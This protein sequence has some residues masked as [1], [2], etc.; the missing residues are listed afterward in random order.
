MAERLPHKAARS[1]VTRGCQTSGGNLSAEEESPSACFV[2]TVPSCA[3]V[4]IP[5]QREGTNVCANT[6]LNVEESYLNPL[7]AQ[8][9]GENWELKSFEISSSCCAMYSSQLVDNW[10]SWWASGQLQDRVVL[11][12]CQTSQ[13]KLLWGTM[14]RFSPCQ[15][16]TWISAV[17][18]PRHLKRILASTSK[19]WLP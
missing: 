10:S 12:C 15:S 4:G 7:A 11:P 19:P 16:G 8:L 2:D 9:C 3:L 5:W 14:K 18:T 6:K 13:R 1:S 17:H